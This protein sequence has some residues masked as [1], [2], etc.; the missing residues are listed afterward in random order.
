MKK[1]VNNSGAMSGGAGDLSREKQ[2]SDG[3]QAAF[4]GKRVLLCEDNII[5]VMLA[6]KLLEVKGVSVETA[7]NGR[8]GID[9]FGSS[10]KGYYD[11]VLMDI[12]MPEFDGIAAAREIRAC[13]HP[14][15]K[16]VPIIAMTANTE[17]RDIKDCLDAGKF[18]NKNSGI[19]P[20]DTRICYTVRSFFVFTPSQ[21]RSAELSPAW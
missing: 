16:S 1:A 2:S 19:T 3:V 17:E 12:M 21:A 5:N 10:E 7:S 4:A 9:M 6:K 18:R 14:C 15:A 13:S 8:V 20:S 11:A